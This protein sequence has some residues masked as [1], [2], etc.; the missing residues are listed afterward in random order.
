MTESL[1]FSRTDGRPPRPGRPH[2][3]PPW[4]QKDGE[5]GLRDFVRYS[6]LRLNSTVTPSGGL[7]HP[8]DKD[9]E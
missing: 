2:Q 8:L 6:R 5:E 1:R 3:S 9:H 7:V 4:A